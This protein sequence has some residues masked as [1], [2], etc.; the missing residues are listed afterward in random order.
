MA[1]RDEEYYLEDVIFLVESRLF[2]VAKYM[3]VEQ[4]QIFRDMFTLP[5]PKGVEPDG[6]SDK[7]PLLLEGVKSQD[8]V[9][10]LKCLYP[11]QFIKKSNM[12]LEQW[13]VVL[14]LAALYEMI[15]VKA[16]AVRNMTPLLQGLPSLQTNWAKKYDVK[17]WIVPGLNALTM[18][19][20][21]LSE[22]D[23]ELIGLF[24][25]ANL[26]ALREESRRQTNKWK[27]QGC[28]RSNWQ[29]TSIVRDD[30][31][32]SRDCSKEIRTRFNL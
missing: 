3:F 21:P 30:N 26:M 19:A 10:L 11:L 14:K 7:Y 25:A 18:R 17:E 1:N 29:P 4:S 8:F 5:T 13:H 23:I 20:D 16:L 28:G 6:S 31:S 22:E 32:L 12:T 2:K 15:D 24:Y 27:C 9:Q